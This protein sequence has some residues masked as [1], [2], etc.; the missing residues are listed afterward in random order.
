MKSKVFL[1]LQFLIV[2]MFMCV[3]HTSAEYEPY[4]QINL[5]EGAKARLGKGE[6]TSNVAYSPD[7][8]RLVVASSIG[9]WIY[10]AQTGEVLDL[11]TGHTDWVY[12]VSFSPDGETL[13]S[14]SLDD[15]IRL[16]DANTGRHIRTLRGHTA[17]VYSVSFSPD[18]QTLAS[19]SSDD[20]I[21]LW[22]ANTGRHIRT[23]RGHTASVYSVSFS[24]DG[25]TLAS[26]SYD[27]TI[28][29]WDVATGDE[30]RKIIGHTSWVETVVF[31][32]DGKTL[33]S[34]GSWDAGGTI[35]LW[36]VASGAMLHSLGWGDMLIV[37][38]VA[39]SPDGATLASASS[40]GSGI[41]LWDVASG[42]S[43]GFLG[44]FFWRVA[45]VA[46]S[47]DG[48]TLASGG[49]RDTVRLWDVNT[50][51]QI[52]KIIGHTD[53]VE[54]VA[55][56]PDGT[57]LASCGTMDAGD[58]IYLWDVASGAM[59]YSL[60][61]DDIFDIFTVNSV[62]FSPDG[63]TL[64]S[65]SE[66]DTI[67]LWD[68]ATG[69]T[70]RKLEGHT[71]NVNSV[72]F[73]PDGQT[74]A[75]G[76]EGGTIRLWEV[77]TGDLIHTLEGHTDNVN[78][79]SFSPD[80]KMLASGSLDDTVRLWDISTGTLIRTLEGHTDNVNSVSFSPDG[81]T[82]ASGSLD[83]TVRLWDISTG[84]LIRTL[85]GHTD[86]VNS[87]S[88][89]PDGQTLASGSG[90]FWG[91]DNTVRLWNVSTGTLIRTLE[92]HTDN[93]NSVS[94]SPDGQTLASGSDGTILL[95]DI[96]SVN[97]PA[98]STTDEPGNTRADAIPLH[99]DNTP[100]TEEID[101]GDD[102]DYFSI[103][104]D[105]AGE[106]I[107]WTTGDLDTVGALQNSEGTTL[108]ENDDENRD[109][110][111]FNFR[112]VHDVEPGTYYIK[113]QSYETA[114][115]SYT[116]SAAFTAAPTLLVDVNG[117]GVVNVIDL[118]I[119]AVNFGTTDAT[120]VQ[121]DVNGD[122]E[123]NR[124]DIIAVL[125]ALEA[126]E[127]VGAP[128]AVSTTQSLQQWID[129]AKQLNR[130]DATFQKGVAMLEQL[131]ATWREAETVPKETALLAN[132]PNPFN[133]ETWIPYQLAKSA[134]VTLTIYAA[135]GK[136]VRTLELRHQSVG[137]YQNKSQAAYWDGK[138]ALGEPVASGLYFYTLTTGD[139]T[140]TR[141]MLIRK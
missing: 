42:N 92:G 63:Q 25:Q 78:S 61:S 115:G 80:G 132:Y 44:G 105:E 45:S 100:L 2:L 103:Q 84:T 89:S 21:R 71:D 7:G 66:D 29:L 31:S 133:P 91:D 3:A 127:A 32:P 1:S 96:T 117:D 136:L 122:G 134:V 137:I 70:I 26:G 125:E 97:E 126:Q 107:V 67:H 121:G 86:N 19:G 40:D 87:V 22:D 5:P 10:D 13:V 140:A 116:I 34:C 131:V 113:V 69:D 82:L 95:W 77:A 62:V 98:T 135:D 15:T 53:T 72:S 56:S 11:L 118:V 57:T 119:V 76:G 58:A 9:I 41:Y 51:E 52:R 24:P 83:D 124:E 4:T 114:T 54:S 14:G 50:R 39:F 104:V 35:Y 128:A 81:Q 106:L 99:I 130:T 102:V 38:S 23:L 111:E 93:V 73:S 6:I 47:P 68:V 110:D 101:P 36:N 33:A 16:W 90:E 108:A 88:F 65:G 129:R 8:T 64:A 43:L 12:S 37:N 79:V 17:S 59:L 18:G 49:G 141:K 109:A 120:A 60:G 30:I 20:T 123:V 74:L 85:E 27:D 46:F 139:F 48:N 75:S 28:R 138:N 94:F 112:I 55:F